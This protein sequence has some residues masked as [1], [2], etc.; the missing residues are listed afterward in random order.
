MKQVHL[1]TAASSL[2][3]SIHAP[4]GPKNAVLDGL[5]LFTL[6]ILA[7]SG[8]PQLGPPAGVAF[9]TGWPLVFT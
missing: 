7:L 6:A 9:V 3:T 2:I 1:R 4:V 8:S 5:A